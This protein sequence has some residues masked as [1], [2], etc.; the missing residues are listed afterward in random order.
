[1]AVCSFGDASANHSTAVGAINTAIHS[2]YQGLPM[3][4][5]FVCEDNGIGISTKTPHG[6]IAANYGN[7]E[8]L[9][10]LRRRRLRSLAD[11]RHRAA[12]R[13]LGAQPPASRVPAPAHRAVD[14]PRRL[15]LSKPAYRKPDEILADFDRDP[16]LSTARTLVD[17]GHPDPTDILDRYETS[18]P[19]SIG[20]GQ[21][22]RRLSTTRR[23]A[24]GDDGRCTTGLE[25]ALSTSTRRTSGRRQVALRGEPLTLALAINRALLDVL[26]ERIPRHWCSV[27]TSPA[28][29]G[30]TG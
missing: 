26:L 3:P 15:R 7:R 19:R 27:R 29:A 14:G 4:L 16:V 2:A 23:R 28:R 20:L 5:L 8:G 11:L 17:A 1:M 9:R 10:V 25:E 18:A 13:Q 30:C 21:R 22:G 12:A 24:R 6:W